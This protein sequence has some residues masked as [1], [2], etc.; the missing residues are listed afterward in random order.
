MATLSAA[1]VKHLNEPGRYGDGGGLYL[2]VSQ[3]RTKSWVFRASIAGKRRD[4]GLGPYPAV[5]LRR[6]R[7]IAADNRT[8]I[9]EGRDPRKQRQQARRTNV[10]TP[11]F[12]DEAAAYYSFHLPTW[13]N[14]KVRK[15]WM[16]PLETY[17]FD[18][19]GDMSVD[20][21]ETR[22]VLEVLE[23]L[24]NTK[25]ET[26]RR[27]RSRIRQVLGWSIARGHARQNAVDPL[28]YVLKPPKTVRHFKSLHHAEVAGVLEAVEQ[29]DSGWAAKWGFRFLVL[30]ATRSAEVRLARWDEIDENAKVWTIPGERTKTSREHRVPL[31]TGALSVLD[32]AHMLRETGDY[33]FPSTWERSGPLSENTWSKL[34][35]TLGVDAVPHGFRSSF[36]T[37]AAESTTASHAAMELSLGHVVG[38]AVEQ[39][40]SRTDLLDQR[41]ALMQS[42]SDYVGG[43]LTSE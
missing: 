14:A 3:G 35:K 25:Y 16:T 1:K 2:N 37:W 10:S 39:A 43:D 29:S 41:R 32:R 38:S 24:W 34:L 23:P 30:T 12:A 4:I 33:I 6:A 21:I 9:A 28:R 13:K 36:R 15:S 18:V 19:L 26:A 5:S 22:D 7:E 40:Y 31:S 11:T 42:W 8:A 17:A 20:E 27:V